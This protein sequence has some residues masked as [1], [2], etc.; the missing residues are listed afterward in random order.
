MG[1]DAELGLRLFADELVLRMIPK[2]C[3]V[4]SEMRDRAEP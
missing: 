2:V 1:A 4:A 3:P